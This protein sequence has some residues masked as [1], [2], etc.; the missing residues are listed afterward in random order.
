MTK[1]IYMNI[2][3]C[4][5]CGES[6]DQDLQKKKGR[7]CRKCINQKRKDHYNNKEKHDPEIIS[8]NRERANNWYNNQPKEELSDKKKR[9]Y[10]ENRDIILE[11]QKIYISNNKEKISEYN[12]KWRLENADHLKAYRELNKER[13]QLNTKEWKSKNKSRITDYWSSY[14]DLNK[15]RLKENSKEYRSKN[16][17][18][19]RDKCKIY[20]RSNRDKIVALMAKRRARKLNATPKWLTEDDYNAIKD[21][22]TEAQRLTLETGIDHVVDHIHPLLGE[23]VCG[24]HVPWNLQILTKSD[25][26]SKGN[27]LIIEDNS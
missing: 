16:I 3:S 27:R 9:Y 14:Y 24:L 10:L 18:T 19:V 17:D 13:D 20:R 1:Y 22:Y 15:D 25:N 4:N 2:K 23:F 21:F 12:K 8:K 6:F 26:C 11:N 5:S 7:V